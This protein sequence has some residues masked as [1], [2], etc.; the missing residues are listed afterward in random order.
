MSIRTKNKL[1]VAANWKMNKSL[2]EAILYGEWF[3]KQLFKSNIEVILHVPYLFLPSMYSTLKNT[4]IHLGAQN[5][6]NF[7]KGAYTGEISAAMLVS[8]GTRF[9]LIGHSERRAFFNETNEILLQKIK[10][11]LSHGLKIIFCC[12]ESMEQRESGTTEGIILAQLNETLG[13]LSVTELNSISIAYEPIWA[14]GTGLTAT[15]QQAQDIHLLIRNWLNHTFGPVIAAQ[16]AIL[17]GGS[18][19]TSNAA[20]LF[21]MPDIDGGL[22]GGASLAEKEFY[23]LIK[24]AESCINHT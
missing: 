21:N 11:A 24:I 23:Q 12:G 16:T 15:S 2:E 20:E 10:Q 22:I 5:C 18:C 8:T 14:I 1:I 19:N 4:S 7:E 6:S 9:V 13:K 3:S 17:Y